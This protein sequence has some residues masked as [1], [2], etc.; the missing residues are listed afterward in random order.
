MSVAN[1]NNSNPDN[2]KRTISWLPLI[3]VCVAQIGTSGDNSVLSFAT[4]Q[5]IQNLH[6]SMDQVQLANIVYSLLAGALMVFGGMLGIAK[7]FKKVFLA[8][9]AFCAIGELVAVLTPNMLV[10]VW[11]ARTITGFGAALMIPSVLGI[12]VSLYQGVD[13]VLAF[14]AVGSA[15]GIA[16]IVMPVGAGFIMDSSG[17]EA[18]FGA[19]VTWFTVVFIVG[20]FLIPEIKPNR[21]RVDYSGALFT[22]IGLVLFIIGCSKISVW[23]FIAPMSAPFTVL[24]IS[25]AL[26]M[27][28]LG[29]IVMV[30]TLVYE[31]NVEKAKGAA[32]IPQSF[33][34]TRQVRDG[35][36]VTGL[37]F[38]VVGVCLFILPAWV[39]VVVAQSSTKSAVIIV[40]LAVP[41]IVLSLVLPKKYSWLSPRGV[42]MVSSVLILLGFLVL[43]AALEPADYSSLVYP[44]MFL[45]GLGLGGYSAQSAMIVA[46]ALNSRDAAQSGGVQCSIR[47]VWQAAGVAIIGA[48]FLFGMTA[49]F[50]SRIEEST[51][52]PQ[53]KQTVASYKVVNVESTASM[54]VRMQATGAAAEDVAKAV[55]IYQQAQVSSGRYA[56]IAAFIM[57]LL[58]IPGFI[59][60]QTKGWSERKK[61]A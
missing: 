41:M 18:A 58:H 8:G 21:L 24:G 39:Q 40:Y 27:I 51:L 46:A 28:V 42:V 45:C 56:F 49:N 37:I 36:Y 17:Y 4:S 61:K 38:A 15:T 7:G 30:L 1:V 10:M 35:L 2:E 25:P 33:I 48:V 3:V 47:N 11:G 16:I 53:I 60:I 29:V 55:S 34:R 26:P 22:F 12:I 19:M 13:R 20:F 59:G 23:G 44:G 57:V 54:Q 50:K 43:I 14:G 32:L 52:P 9:A 31:K 5:F 6:A